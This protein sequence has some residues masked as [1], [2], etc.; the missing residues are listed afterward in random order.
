MARPDSGGLIRWAT[1][2][3]PDGPDS[4]R[5]TP[6]H[7]GRERA[8][9]TPNWLW[10]PEPV[11]GALGH[12]DFGAGKI[13]TKAGRKVG[14]LVRGLQ[15]TVDPGTVADESVVYELRFRKDGSA[16]VQGAY[17]GFKLGNAFDHVLILGEPDK[18]L[19]DRP[20]IVSVVMGGCNGSSRA[21]ISTDPEGRRT[22]FQL[23]SH[24][25]EGN[26]GE[27]I[28][29]AGFVR[30]LSFYEENLAR[31]A[32]TFAGNVM[33]HA[34]ENLRCPKV[35]D[36][37]QRAYWTYLLPAMQQEQTSA[38]AYQRWCEEATRRCRQGSDR[39]MEIL[40]EVQ[41]DRFDPADI[42]DR[43]ELAPLDEVLVGMKPGRHAPSLQVLV[44]TMRNSGDELWNLILDPELRTK[45]KFAGKYLEPELRTVQELC[46]ASYVVA[47]LRQMLVGAVM[48]V[49]DYVEQTIEH[50]VQEW[51]RVLT[52]HGK[53]TFRGGSFAVYP[54]SHFVPL[55]QG[56]V[57]YRSDPGRVVS[58]NDRL[59]I[60]GL[61]HGMWV[62]PVDLL[63][64]SYL[65]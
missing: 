34:P 30:E 19:A 20:E 44:D 22:S 49:N 23:G 45:V 51:T 27:F 11:K 2:S 59:G 21:T 54:F 61:Y 32:A 64:E 46:G 42:V 29:S 57:M 26:V 3:D 58:V 25:A 55:E 28:T 17:A 6:V 39:T 35:I 36:V 53:L 1:E 14:D 5:I 38:R 43:D 16:Y 10:S 18:A 56:A 40:R 13:T 52:E 37:P 7:L 41:G 50:F 4:S 9:I 60:S 8:L 62:D 48:S 47:V 12:L 15:L 65:R 63:P 33:A 31:L 24:G